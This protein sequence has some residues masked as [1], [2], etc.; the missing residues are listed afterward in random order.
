MA[1]LRRGRPVVDRVIPRRLRGIRTGHNAGP[2][3]FRLTTPPWLC[4]PSDMLLSVRDLRRLGLEPVSFDLAAGECVAVTGP[5]G[6][7]KTLLLR[8]IAD[9]DPNQG[10]VELGGQ[11]REA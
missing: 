2:I 8:A 5:S 9:L 11:R 10:R 6:S 3:L 7:G 4:V 1:G